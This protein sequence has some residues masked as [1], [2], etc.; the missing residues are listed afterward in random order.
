MN[1]TESL[2]I[3]QA[4]E[5]TALIGDHSESLLELTTSFLKSEHNLTLPRDQIGKMMDREASARL[6]F[7]VG[8]QNPSEIRNPQN[9][10][11][12]ARDLWLDYFIASSDEGVTPEKCI[13]ATE[14]ALKKE[15]NLA[16]TAEK[17]RVHILTT[18]KKFS[19]PESSLGEYRGYLKNTLP[20][21]KVAFYV[22]DEFFSSTPLKA[23]C[24]I[25]NPFASVPSASTE[26][27]GDNSKKDSRVKYLEKTVHDLKVKL[28]YAQKDAVREIIM[29]LASNGYGAPLLELNAVRKDDSTPDHIVAMISNLFLALESLDIRIVKDSSTGKAVPYTDLAEGK[30]CFY[31]DIPPTKNDTIVVKYPGIKLGKEMIVKPMITKES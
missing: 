30:Y 24:D 29:T 17:D 5:I 9:C 6:F 12:I 13:K 25:Y 8:K 18:C 20:Y 11:R 4:I 26:D 3:R 10:L 19:S 14:E 23:V 2:L 1:S 16:L 22:L 31:G 21:Y 7:A 27:K 28:E 15:A